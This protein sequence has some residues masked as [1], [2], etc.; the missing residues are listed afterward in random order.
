M[1]WLIDDKH[2]EPSNEELGI[3]P[4]VNN[5]W[6]VLGV[7]CAYGLMGWAILIGVGWLIFD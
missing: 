7:W 6:F 3:R 5:K 4:W 1:N 2:D